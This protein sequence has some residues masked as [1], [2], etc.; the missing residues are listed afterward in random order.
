[1]RSLLYKL[2]RK[3]VAVYFLANEINSPKKS[4]NRSEFTVLQNHSSGTTTEEN[5]IWL[6]EAGQRCGATTSIAYH[7]LVH[8]SSHPF[9]NYIQACT[10]G[11]SMKHRDFK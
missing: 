1:V 11:T 9:R 4:H 10:P 2:P 6:E 7:L 5:Y 8:Q 3:I